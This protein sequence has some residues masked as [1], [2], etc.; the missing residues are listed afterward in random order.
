MRR[1]T[2]TENGG[3]ACSLATPCGAGGRIGVVGFVIFFVRRVIVRTPA[4]A[5]LSVA[6]IRVID[7][8]GIAIIVSAPTSGRN[9]VAGRIVIFIIVVGVCRVLT[10]VAIVVGAAA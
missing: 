6:V 5:R 4:A 7:V 1:S 8:V 10:I 9:A 3:A 2:T